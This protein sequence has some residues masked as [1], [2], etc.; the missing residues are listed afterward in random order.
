MKSLFR[1]PL[2]L[3]LLLSLPLWVVFGNYIVA[4]TTA[5]LVCLLGMMCM[6]LYILGKK[7]K[8]SPPRD[9]P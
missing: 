6:Q 2:L 5:L 3:A 1:K 9:Q 8:S 7:D 4:I